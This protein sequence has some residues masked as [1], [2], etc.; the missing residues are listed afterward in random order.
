MT[1]VSP[2]EKLALAV[3]FLLL[4]LSLLLLVVEVARADDL[5]LLQKLAWILALFIGTFF[6]AVIYFAQ[7]RTGRLGRAASIS[8]S[9][10]I[11]LAI[12]IIVALALRL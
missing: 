2:F 1:D 9:A 8:M 11:L 4:V 5:S 12:G 3:L 7:G 10:G 6:T